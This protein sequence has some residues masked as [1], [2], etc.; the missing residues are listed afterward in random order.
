MHSTPPANWYPDPT[1]RHQFRY[2]DG[3]AWTEHAAD[4]GVQT[5]DPLESGPTP[6]VRLTPREARKQE[7]VAR[8][9]QIRAE[10]TAQKEL[11]RI[12]RERAAVERAAREQAAR[13]QAR[14]EQDAREQ[15]RLLDEARKRAAQE[16]AE[17]E[18]REAR[19]LEVRALTLPPYFL[20]GYNSYANTEVAGEFAHMDGIHRALGRVPRRDEEIVEEALLA[21]LIPEPTNQ[22]DR[23]AV[24]VVITGQHVGYLEKQVAAAVQPTIRRIV[25]AGYVPVV[26]ARI[27]AVARSDYNSRALKHHANVRLALTDAQRMVPLNDPVF[28]EYSVLPWGSSL[29]VTGE[30]HH[31]DVLSN[32]VTPDGEALVLGTLVLLQAARKSIK[33]VV[34]VRIDGERIGQLTPSS[35]QHFLPTIWHLDSLGMTTAAWLIVKGNLLASQ[36]TIHATRAHEL[37][38]DWF[39]SPHTVPRLQSSSPRRAGESTGGTEQRSQHHAPMWEE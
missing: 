38:A 36:V 6:A 24:K 25:E 10:K 16:A 18:L 27:W 20:P 9:E 4:N 11:A 19:E 1:G 22:F 14:A 5:L 35:S 17:R 15:E 7:K 28:E 34:E 29:Q 39:E 21:Q 23:N 32:Y 8:A 12:E 2:W 30:E 3:D 37:Q 26:G 33:E 31:H 13:D